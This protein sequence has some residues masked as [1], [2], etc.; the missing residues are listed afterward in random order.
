MEPV[1]TILLGWLLGLLTPNLAERIRRPYRRRDLVRAVV[2]EMLS[3]QRTMALV[4]H[5]IRARYANV[6]DAFLDELLPI[7]EAY[8][9]PDRNENLNAELRQSRHR[10]EQERA[11]I[12]QA[13]RQPNAGIVL[14]QYSLPLFVTQLAD[15]TICG[16]DFQR[17]VL[18]IRQQLDLYN[19]LV[20][21]MQWLN[22]RTFTNPT[23]SDKEAIITNWEMAC[24]DAGIRAEY[25]MKAI[26]EL[27]KRF[28]AK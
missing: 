13:M 17:Q 5:R 8:Q 25:V 19:Q 21:Y 24:R 15:L 14:R 23:P 3:L 22:D 12:D 27:Q 9:G 4:A 18:H 11:E 7:V 2:D 26:G 10:S 1:L 20:G 28:G 6:T 16:L